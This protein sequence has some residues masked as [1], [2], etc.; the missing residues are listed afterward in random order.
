[1]NRQSLI[2]KIR[3]AIRKRET[4]VVQW[5]DYRDLIPERWT[6]AEFVNELARLNRCDWLLHNETLEARFFE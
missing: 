6:E 5:S 2:A 1:M 3:R 4:C